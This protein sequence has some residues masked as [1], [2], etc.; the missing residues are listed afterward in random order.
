M[1]YP[2]VSSTVATTGFT[3]A[4]TVSSSGCTRAIRA[5]AS[6]S[7]VRVDP[8]VNTLADLLRP[9]N[10][11]HPMRHFG[12]SSRLLEDV[13]GAKTQIIGPFGAVMSIRVDMPDVGDALLFEV[14]FWTPWLTR[15]RP[16]LLP[17]A[18]HSSFSLCLAAAGS[19]TSS[20]GDSAFG[21]EENPPT[22]ANIP[23]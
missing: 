17:Q 4:F 19:G 9:D 18:S 5:R 11:L 20:A 8:G 23:R 7:I 1:F 16:A 15:I 21:A 12:V 13:L 10:F 2:S 6:A 3:K 14:V 22:Q